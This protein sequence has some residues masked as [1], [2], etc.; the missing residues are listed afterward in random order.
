MFAAGNRNIRRAA[1]YAGPHRAASSEINAY[2][3][4]VND[5]NRNTQDRGTAR[6]ITVEM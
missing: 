2:L 4:S 1:L 6:S 5:G 3:R